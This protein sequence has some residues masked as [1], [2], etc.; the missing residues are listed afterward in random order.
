[1]NETNPDLLTTGVHTLTIAEFRKKVK[2][3]FPHVKLS[4]RT[5]SFQDLARCSRKCLELANM[6]SF[7]EHG[8]INDWA[9]Q[10]GVIP[11][12]SIHGYHTKTT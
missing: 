8:T 10:A 1:M 2:Q 12:T 9:R 4:I 3:Q 5:V 11:D 7:T 6:Q